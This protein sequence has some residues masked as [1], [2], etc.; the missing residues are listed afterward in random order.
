MDHE[1]LESRPALGEDAQISG[2]RSRCHNFYHDS[3]CLWFLGTELFLCRISD[4]KNFEIAP[5]IMQNLCISGNK[6]TSKIRT[7]ELL[8]GKKLLN[9]SHCHMIYATFREFSFCI[10]TNFATLGPQMRQPQI[11]V[12]S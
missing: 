7:L 6:N 2:V 8:Y 3:S 9:D 5:S 4:A 10:E 1:L 11:P 12:T